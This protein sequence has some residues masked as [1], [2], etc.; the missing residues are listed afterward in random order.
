[1]EVTFR[2]HAAVMLKEYPVFTNWEAGWA[3][4]RR[5]R[6][7]RS[8]NCRA[9]AGNWTIAPR[10]YNRSRLAL[11]TEQT[12]LHNSESSSWNCVC[13]A[14]CI[15]FQH[16]TNKF[17]INYIKKKSIFRY[18]NLQGVRLL[19]QSYLPVKMHYET[20]GGIWCF[21]ISVLWHFNWHVTL[22]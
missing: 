18:L 8:E 2:L 9:S 1:M 4:E 12:D 6:L 11:L 19:Y 20:H 15:Y 10:S 21:V 7:R 13:R 3:P 5:W 14:F 17:T 22:V 16:I